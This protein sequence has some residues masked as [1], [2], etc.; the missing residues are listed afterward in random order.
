LSCTKEFYTNIE[1]SYDV[2]GETTSEHGTW[3]SDEGI[4]YNL[5]GR[6]ILSLPR[7]RFDSNKE[8]IVVV[9]ITVD[10][11][12]RVTDASPG[13]KGSTTLDGHL[14]RVSMEAALQARFEPKPDAPI[15]Q[16]GTITYKF[17]LK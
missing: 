10:R 16:K 6:R 5:G 1:S 8:G 15:V 2:S 12:G 9:G 7:P 14:L 3:N 17:M 13:I 11:D 4:S